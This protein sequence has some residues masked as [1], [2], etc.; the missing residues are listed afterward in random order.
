MAT[1]TDAHWLRNQ[2]GPNV[3]FYKEYPMGHV[4]FTAGKATDHIDDL[5]IFLRER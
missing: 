1:T 4:G 5:L 2:L 3:K